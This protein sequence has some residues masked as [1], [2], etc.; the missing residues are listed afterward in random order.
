MWR[1][2]VAA[3]LVVAVLG[4]SLDL[5][6]VL[7]KEQARQAGAADGVMPAAATS[8]RLAALESPGAAPPAP[9]PIPAPAAADDAARIALVIGNADYQ[10]EGAALA[11]PVND[12]QAI[13]TALR[14]RGFDVVAGGNLTRQGMEDTIAAF[15]AKVVP[16][17][18]A[19]IFFSGYGIQSGRQ[20]YLIPVDAQIWRE[21]DVRHDGIAIEPIL[22]G[23]E[24]KGAAA[25]LLVVDASRRNPYERRFRG[26]SIGLAPIS[27][28]A[29][30][31]VIYASAP[32]KVARDSEGA[33]S[34]FMTELLD[35]LRRDQGS[36]EEIFNR[37]R[38]EVARASQGEQVPG[39]FSALTE[40]VLIGKR[41]DRMSEI[42]DEGS[43]DRDQPSSGGQ[44]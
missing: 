2:W 28:P 19:L 25:K 26:L 15:N 10:D 8:E 12:A 42:S 40:H 13:A 44:R 20:S 16:G 22:A 17:A 23:L 18:T 6:A 9:R 27:T 5:A 11:Q 29:G 35:Q 34:L 43:A 31:L 14:N 41:H 24:E 38:R 30:T 33:N 1:M 7:N 21:A 36:A 37:T 3:S 32:G 4:F 39:V